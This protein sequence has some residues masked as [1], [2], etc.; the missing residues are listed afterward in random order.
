MKFIKLK[1]SLQEN[2][3]FEKQLLNEL[4]NLSKTFPK[5][6]QITLLLSRQIE[7]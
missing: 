1:N 7:I 2:S 6:W 5:N 3:L 4:K